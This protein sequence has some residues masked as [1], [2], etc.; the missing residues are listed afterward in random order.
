MKIL[1]ELELSNNKLLHYDVKTIE[2]GQGRPKKE[3]NITSVIIKKAGRP[4]KVI[5][6]IPVPIL[7]PIIPPDE[8]VT[9]PTGIPTPQPPVEAPKK[10]VPE[11]SEALS[12]FKPPE[13]SEAQKKHIAEL[14][15]I[16]AGIERK[17]ALKRNVTAYEK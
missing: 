7:P 10:P 8:Q 16:L 11:P 1:I 5:D 6:I 2:Q 12:S 9:I 17:K 3:N 15:I 13:L 4:K 14:K